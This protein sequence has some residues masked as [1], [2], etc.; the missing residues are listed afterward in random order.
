MSAQYLAAIYW[1]KLPKLF[2]ILV[3]AS[4]SSSEV[5][6]VGI[7]ATDSGHHGSPSNRVAETILTL[8]GLS[9]SC[10]NTTPPSSTFP[11]ILSLLAVA[12]CVTVNSLVIVFAPLPATTVIIA[13]RSSSALFS[14]KAV[15]RRTFSVTE[16]LHHSSAGATTVACNE[17]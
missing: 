10:Q 14:V 16:T 5:A 6:P 2:N 13:V 17:D 4:P 1:S 9:G 15:I 3:F 8:L 12:S 7:S 11:I